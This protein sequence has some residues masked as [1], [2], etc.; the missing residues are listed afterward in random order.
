MSKPARS[1]PQ[2]QT[3]HAVYAYAVVQSARAPALAKLPAGIPGASRP[4]ALAL[5]GGLWLVIADAPLSQYGSQVIETHLRDLD[6]VGARAIGHEALVEKLASKYPA[7]PLKLLTLFA[8][9][10]RALA[11]LQ[12]DRA[13][14]LRVMGRIRGCAEWG[15]RVGFDELA[16]R[17]K[18]Q[19]EARAESSGSS[20]TAF[21]LKKKK[22]QQISRELLGRAQ[23]Q[24][25]EL[26]NAL[27]KWAKQA[28]RRPPGKAEIGA[29]ILLEA[30]FLVPAKDRKRFEKA[31]AER[32][33]ALAPA[34]Y[35]VALTGPWP[36]YNFVAESA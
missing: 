16:A 30:A 29:R 8:T 10:A 6:W 27:S 36:V 19:S 14:L 26:F 13:R 20:G 33:R 2:S 28:R 32:T 12:P 17:R 15:L 35:S 9:E 25:D 4:R 22:E 34:G 21:L 7:V 1:S 3:V 18:A 23:A 11:Q 5:G 24:V 31:V